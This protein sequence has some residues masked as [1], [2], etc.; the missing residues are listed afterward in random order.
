MDYRHL[1]LEPISKEVGGPLIMWV[2]EFT[3][4]LPMAVGGTGADAKPTQ[5]DIL[6][7]AWR[8]DGHLGYSPDCSRRRL[9]ACGT[10]QPSKQPTPKPTHMR[11]ARAIFN[12]LPL[13]RVIGSRVGG[14]GSCK[15]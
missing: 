4:T 15:L 14:G 8:V 10:Q 5:W 7:P 11:L 13:A 3:R 9:P 2:G 6:G 1:E 12:S